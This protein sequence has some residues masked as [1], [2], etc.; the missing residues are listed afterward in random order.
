MYPKFEDCTFK[1]SQP[2][3]P[4]CT[5]LKISLPIA[6]ISLNSAK[7]TKSN[8]PSINYAAF[9]DLR[10]LY[11]ADKFSIIKR[12]PKLTSK[13]C[14]PS[15]LERQNVKLALKVFH[16]STAAG[17]SSFNHENKTGEN[18]HTVEFIN[19][20]NQIWNIFNVNWVGK[21]I[22]FN[23]P[24]L[25]PL[26]LNDQ[27]L[28]LLDNVVKLLDFWR[29]IPTSSG[30]L[31]PQTFTS[32]RH[33]CIA[34]SLLVRR[35]TVECGFEY[36][37]TSRVQN[38]PLEHHFGLYRQMSGSNYNISYSQVLESERRLQLS[39]ILKFFYIKQQSDTISLKEYLQT[40]TEDGNVDKMQ[41]E[42]N[43]EYFTNE[44]SNIDSPI[45]DYSQ[46]ECLNY[47]AGYAVFSY[48]KLFPHCTDCQN[49]LTSPKDIEVDNDTGFSLIDLLDRGSLKYP[50]ESVFESVL[51]IYEIFLK[52]DSS[53]R[54]SR[55]F[56]EGSC[57]RN[58]VQLAILRRGARFIEQGG[59]RRGSQFCGGAS[60]HAAKSLYHII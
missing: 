12:A 10:V 8:Y 46:I 30:K 52:I 13:A 5:Q 14:W 39:N 53:S 24:L 21:D 59:Q 36:L 20:I 33:T 45:F 42:I 1:Q 60:F 51:I 31:T 23:N 9:D 22:R 38:D 58:L 16:E 49:F 28:S 19:L 54:L 26:H 6:N 35:L 29:A 47:V 25:A 3:N 4:P 56:Y 7:L 2:V 11:K 32:F 34:L 41:L 48:L 43:L 37:L 55:L 18:C 15:H 40:F 17:L 44:I 50:S 27:K 57:R